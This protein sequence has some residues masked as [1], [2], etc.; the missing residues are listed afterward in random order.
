MELFFYLSIGCLFYFAHFMS[1][2]VKYFKYAGIVISLLSYG[3]MRYRLGSYEGYVNGYE[4]GFIDATSRN[5]GYWADENDYYR[6]ISAALKEIEGNESRMSEK[7]K[8]NRA[9]EI[10]TYLKIGFCLSSS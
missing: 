3:V 10:R 9:E 1:S 2:N 5:C 8:E 4:Q 7:H 6:E